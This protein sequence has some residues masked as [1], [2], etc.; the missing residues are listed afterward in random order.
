MSL[1]VSPS[2]KRFNASIKS[3]CSNETGLDRHLIRFRLNI[4]YILGKS[5]SLTDGKPLAQWATVVK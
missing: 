2:C 4:D 1:G 3:L 5:P